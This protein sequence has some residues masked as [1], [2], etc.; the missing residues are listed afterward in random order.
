MDPSFQLEEEMS[1]A[2]KPSYRGY[3][4]VLSWDLARETEKTHRNLRKASR[5]RGRDM[6]SVRL[7]L[8][9]V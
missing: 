2:E 4:G 8:E 3:S 5:N 6:N 7:E 9:A 1:R